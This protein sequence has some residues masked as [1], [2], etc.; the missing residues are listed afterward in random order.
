A[1]ALHPGGGT[2]GPK[3]PRHVARGYLFP[4]LRGRLLALRT[5][6][7]ESGGLPAAASRL[8]PATASGR[9][10]RERLLAAAIR[11]A[12]ARALPSLQ[13]YNRE[14]PISRNR[15]QRS[16]HVDALEQPDPDEVGDEGAPTVGDE[17]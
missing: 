2:A 12:Q 10:R 9:R 6:S 8:L 3:N 7:S 17:R 14:V 16:P 5:R 15:L 1:R 13:G 11:G 4:P